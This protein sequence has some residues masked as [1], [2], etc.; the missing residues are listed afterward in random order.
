MLAIISPGQGSQSPG[1]LTPWLEIPRN[2]DL[3]D[4]WGTTIGLDLKK[5]G[6]FAPSD[7]IKSTDIAQ[8]LIFSVSVLSAL[9]LNIKPQK[10][11]SVIFAGHSVGE[12]AAYALAGVFD[13][14]DAL[15]IVAARG[16]SMLAATR[17]NA[18]TGMYAVMGGERKSVIQRLEELNLTPANIN[19]RNQVITAGEIKNLEILKNQPP[20]GSRVIPLEVSAAFHSIFMQSAVS[21]VRAAFEHVTV[22]N[23]VQLICTNKNGEFI[24]SRDEIIENLINQVVS[25]VRWDLCQRTFVK[26]GVTGIL[27]LSPSGVLSGIS[28]KENP[29]IET[30]GIKSPK[31]IDEANEFIKRHIG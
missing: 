4:S 11:G 30:F 27:E 14:N 1:M 8:L 18:N 12:F 9:D 15:K 16:K 29:D 19:S 13:F 28:K 31:D 21:E 2:A 10:P 25:P 7:D 5:I 17:L 24:T 23:P 22:H 26:S 20:E 6:Q 3:T